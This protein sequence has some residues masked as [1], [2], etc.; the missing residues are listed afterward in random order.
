MNDFYDTKNNINYSFEYNG[1]KITDSNGNADFY[2]YTGMLS[3]EKESYTIPVKKK[4]L[5]RRNATVLRYLIVFKHEKAIIK[6]PVDNIAIEK[7]DSCIQFAG[8]RRDFLINKDEIEKQK[9]K[10]KSKEAELRKAK[11]AECHKK[12]EEN[13]D[14]LEKLNKRNKEIKEDYDNRLKNYIQLEE[15]LD[16]AKE[17]NECYK[18]IDEIEH[19]IIYYGTNETMNVNAERELIKSR[20]KALINAF[21]EDARARGLYDNMIHVEPFS[22]SLN[23]INDYIFDTKEKLEK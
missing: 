16:M 13:P 23:F 6:I 2:S 1:L 7:A 8:E 20:G 18:D 3:I 22:D 4:T 5:F 12:M 10:V 11:I 21:I 14:E 9:L 19:N 17:L 15:F